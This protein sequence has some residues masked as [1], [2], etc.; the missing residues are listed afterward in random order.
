MPSLRRRF[1]S[2]TRV[3]LGLQILTSGLVLASWLSVVRVSDGLRDLSA[4]R[5]SVLAFGTAARE[6]YVHQAHSFVEG[7]PGHLDHYGHSAEEARARLDALQEIPLR[8]AAAIRAELDRD[9]AAFSTWFDSAARPAL[10]AGV[11]RPDAVRLHEEAEERIV[12]IE[13]DTARL[14]DAVERRQSSEQA[15]LEGALKRAVLASVALAGMAALIQL[16]IAR[17][18]AGAVLDPLTRLAEVATRFG[19]GER[20]AR[21]PE[22]G[23]DELAALGRSFN[24]MFHAVT[25]AE[26]RRVRSERLAALGE[27]SAAIAHELN[28]PLTVI[29]GT[30]TDPVVRHEAEHASRV[31]RGLLGFAR[32]GEEPEGPVDLALLAAE[33]VSRH[34]PWADARDLV[35]E[36]HDEGPLRAQVSPAAARQILDNLLRNAI[37]AA[38]AGTIIELCVSRD[39]VSVLDRGPGLPATIRPRLYE[40]FATGRADGTGLGLA[41]CQRIARAQGG[42]IIHEDRPEGGTIATWRP[43]RIE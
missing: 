36:L 43:G 5:L 20:A 19:Q 11:D 25:E 28:N 38:P 33:A 9:H 27:L 40:P 2:G 42:S 12:K 30:T 1:L 23:D 32:P 22:G 21:A 15:R 14:L 26:D 3:L 35:L 6:Q 16:G 37:E 10:L 13:A 31:V 7:G 41:V 4:W 18:L 17:K 24:A 34:G 39:A 8:E 29:L